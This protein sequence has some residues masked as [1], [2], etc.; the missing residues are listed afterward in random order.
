MNFLGI[1]FRQFSVLICEVLELIT[2]DRDTLAL[3]HAAYK[4]VTK[5]LPWDGSCC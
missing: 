4:S 3:I 5:A 1:P 2:D